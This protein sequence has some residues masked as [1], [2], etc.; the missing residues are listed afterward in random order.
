MVDIPSDTLLE[1]TDFPFASEYQLQITSLLGGERSCG[2]LN[3]N[4]PYRLMHLNTWS[5][6]VAPLGGV[7]LLWK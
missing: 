7:P 1:K 2:G 3:R 4:G 6:G 5:I